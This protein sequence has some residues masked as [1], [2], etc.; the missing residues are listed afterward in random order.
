MAAKGKRVLSLVIIGISILSL[1]SSSAPSCL[2]D[3]DCYSIVARFCRQRHPPPALELRSV[4]NQSSYLCTSIPCTLCNGRASCRSIVREQPYVQERRGV[5]SEPAA[6]ALQLE[7]GRM[8]KTTRCRSLL[9]PSRQCFSNEIR[10]THLCN[11]RGI[12]ISEL[13]G[14]V[15]V[16]ADGVLFFVIGRCLNSR[17]RVALLLIKTIMADVWPVVH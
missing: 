7:V 1:L 4:F 10:E 14:V 5:V 16:V 3:F 8:N 17:H 12:L 6:T 13:V 11:V 15:V 2:V 9:S